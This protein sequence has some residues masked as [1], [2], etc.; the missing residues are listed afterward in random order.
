MLLYPWQRACCRIVNTRELTA[1]IL[2]V[3]LLACDM[4]LGVVT[5]SE[6]VHHRECSLAVVRTLCPVCGA[7]RNL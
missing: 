6:D 2:G 7:V 1:A 4:T 5:W 3:R